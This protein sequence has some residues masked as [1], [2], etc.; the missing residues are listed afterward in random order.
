MDASEMH[1]F[2]YQQFISTTRGDT[3]AEVLLEMAGIKKYFTGVHALANAYIIGHKGEVHALVGENGAG[4]STRMKILT[5]IFKKDGGT[6][7][8]RGSVIEPA[9]PQHLH[10]PLY[11]NRTYPYQP[12]GIKNKYW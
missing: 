3:V 4:K 2:I 11:P 8:Y 10:C 9:N 5:G 12:E 7:K 1:S 6:I